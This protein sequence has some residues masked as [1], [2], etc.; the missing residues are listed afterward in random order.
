M[1]TAS[2]IKKEATFD[3]I[4]GDLKVTIVDMDEYEPGVSRVKAKITGSETVFHDTIESMV[5]FLNDEG[6]EKSK[7]P[8]MV[9]EAI[10]MTKPE[11][12]KMMKDVFDEEFKKE[13]DKEAKKMVDNDDVKDIVRKMLKKQYRTFWEK[14]ALFLDRL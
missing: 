12:K 11:L 8:H 4:G 3:E 14:S 9:S 2:D 1:I 10:D 13:F 6:Y 7:T 5:G